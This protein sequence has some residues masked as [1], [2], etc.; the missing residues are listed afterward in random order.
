MSRKA[1][2][3]RY[4]AALFTE[5]RGPAFRKLDPRALVRNPVIFVTAVVA[6]LTTTILVSTP[7]G[8]PRRALA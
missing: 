3:P 4:T 6:V 7:F 5:A 2:Q 8:P 1:A